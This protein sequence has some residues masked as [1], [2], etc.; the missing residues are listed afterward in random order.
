VEDMD[1]EYFE[2]PESSLGTY[3]EEEEDGDDLLI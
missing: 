2:A 3:K 1:V